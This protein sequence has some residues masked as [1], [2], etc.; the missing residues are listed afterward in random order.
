G[1]VDVSFFFFFKQKTADVWSFIGIAPGPWDRRTALAAGDGRDLREHDVP[2]RSA[3]AAARQ[4]GAR[5]RRHL[6]Y[7]RGLLGAVLERHRD[8]VGPR[9]V[10]RLDGPGHLAL[11]KLLVREVGLLVED[12]HRVEVLLQSLPPA[13]DPLGLFLAVGSPYLRRPDDPPPVALDRPSLEPEIALHEPDT[14]HAV[15]T[16]DRGGDLDLLAG[17]GGRGRGH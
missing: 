11:G 6:T 9:R 12:Q 14:D 17:L 13:V 4:D 7:R 5:R 10:G 3:G 2:G 1:A 8:V 15:P 16:T